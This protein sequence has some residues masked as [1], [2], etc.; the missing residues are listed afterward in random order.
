[1]SITSKTCARR[2]ECNRDNETAHILKFSQPFGRCLH[3]CVR[4]YHK[5]LGI[6][7]RVNTDNCD[8]TCTYQ[9]DM[10]KC[11]TS[12]MRLAAILYQ[13]IRF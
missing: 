9:T 7:A 1:M 12:I 3:M 4:V 5:R 11:L 13:S 2:T 6:Y 10:V 8:H